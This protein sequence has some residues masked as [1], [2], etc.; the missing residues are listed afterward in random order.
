MFR[1]IL[2]FA[3]LA[4]AAAQAETVRLTPEQAEAAIAAGA[5]RKTLA[6]ETLPEP[7]QLDRG[8]HGEVGVAVG[9]GGYRAFHGVVGLPLGETGSLTLG[10]GEER[11]RAL[12]WR[13]DWCRGRGAAACDVRFNGAIPEPRR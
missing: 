7:P 12:G 1:L 2:A 8:V 6:A 3:C 5:A 9:T 11:G 4:P 13:G 10:Y